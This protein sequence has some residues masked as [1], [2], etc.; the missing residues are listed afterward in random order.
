MPPVMCLFFVLSCS[1]KPEALESGA[2]MIG[3]AK[4]RNAS[5]SPHSAGKLKLPPKDGGMTLREALAKRRSVRSF[6]SREMTLEQIGELLW[7]G[8]GV[9]STQGFRTT[10][11]AGA[12]FPLELHL[13]SASGVFRYEPQS[14][15]L[16]LL[17]SKDRRKELEE[18]ALHQTCIGEGSINIIIAGISS[19]TSWKY[20]PRTERYV[21]M[22]AGAA[23]QNI[24]LTATALGFGS[25]LVGAFEDNAVARVARLP[26][27]SVPYAIIPIGGK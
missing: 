22:E 8:Q 6:T 3:F 4:K 9:T 11:S 7:A 23:A 24:L 20:G 15:S 18:A 27:E 25:V 17:D 12:T 2:G 1:E 13:V 19:R 16:A 14:H 10:P 26:K 21:A 5:G